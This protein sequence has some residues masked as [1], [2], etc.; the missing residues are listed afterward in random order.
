MQN[1]LTISCVVAAVSLQ[2]KAPKAIINRGQLK[3]SSATL[4]DFD[5]EGRVEITFG[6]IFGEIWIWVDFVEWGKLCKFAG[7]MEIARRIM[8]NCA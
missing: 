4:Y 6:R 2:S 3:S 8:K 1:L 7:E 5:G